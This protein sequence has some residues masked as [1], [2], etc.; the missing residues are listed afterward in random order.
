MVFPG[1]TDDCAV[2]FFSLG[3]LKTVV[4]WHDTK[5]MTEHTQIL[6]LTDGCEFRLSEMKRR[7]LL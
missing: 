3:F 6:K 4:F 5:D 7:F 2:N 1:Q